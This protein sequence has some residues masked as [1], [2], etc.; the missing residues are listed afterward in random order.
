VI[1]LQFINILFP[2]LFHSDLQSELW[3]S[4]V[5]A[6]QQQFLMDSASSRDMQAKK[7]PPHYPV[8]MPK[9]GAGGR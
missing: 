6:E 4:R 3:P 2:R 1:T 7:K 8:G 5:G 9:E